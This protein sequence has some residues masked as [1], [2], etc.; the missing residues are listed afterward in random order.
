V[1]KYRNGETPDFVKSYYSFILS[2]DKIGNHNYHY[3]DGKHFGLGSKSFTCHDLLMY[4]EVKQMRFDEWI[5]SQTIYGTS[6]F[7]EGFKEGAKALAAA[8]KDQT[9]II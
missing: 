7:I 2:I 9:V 6:G 5:S 4:R 8:I 1:V 3:S